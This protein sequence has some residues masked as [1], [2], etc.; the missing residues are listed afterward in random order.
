[1][2]PPET[3]LLME[4]MDASLDHDCGTDPSLDLPVLSQVRR[5][6][7]QGW[8]ETLGNEQMRPYF[9]RKEEL[10]TER[11]CLL[12]GARVIV[13]PQLRTQVLEEIHE[14]S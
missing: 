1:V 5:H 8:L 9:Q 3:V 4:R 7:M 6:V 12:W 2:Q 11:G 14:G 10:S 13:P